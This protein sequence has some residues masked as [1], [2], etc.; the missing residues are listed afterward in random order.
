MLGIEMAPVFKDLV[1]GT[2]K[3]CICVF[4]SIKLKVTNVLVEIKMW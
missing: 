2:N 3:T 1:M 4:L